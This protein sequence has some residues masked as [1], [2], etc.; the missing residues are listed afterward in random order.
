MET[1]VSNQ[2]KSL[3]I[4]PSVSLVDKSFSKEKASQCHLSVAIGEQQFSYSV[5]DLKNSRYL[6]L[7]E[8][9]F[10]NQLGFN[11][12]SEKIKEIISSSVMEDCS[13]KSIS[14]S[15]IHLKATLVPAPLFEESKKADYLRFNFQDSEEENTAHDYLQNLDAYNIYA[16]PQQANDALKQFFPNVKMLHYSSVLIESAI[17]PPWRDEK[18]KKVYLHLR[19]AQLEIIVTEDKKLIFYNSFHFESKEDIAY[20][21]LFVCEQLGLNPHE[22]SVT[23][24]GK[25]RKT[26]EKFIFLETYVKSIVLSSRPQQFG[27]SYVF[28]ETPGHFYHALFTQYLLN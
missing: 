18:T 15:I 2:L 22:I 25:I 4:Q 3:S 28:D 23:V 16:L 14:A 17:I 11:G 7:E 5:L 10:E 24:T 6:A 20:Y 13:F 27:Y 19:D 21:L 8:F 1:G 12:I 26:E 9:Q